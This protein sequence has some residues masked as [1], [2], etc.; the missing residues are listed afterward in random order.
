MKMKNYRDWYSLE[1]TALWK[2]QIQGRKEGHEQG[3][4]EGRAEGRKEE[5]VKI[6]VKMKAKGMSSDVISQFTGL[7]IQEIEELN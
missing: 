3:L 4:R 2:G 7:T 5:K 6:A 1:Q